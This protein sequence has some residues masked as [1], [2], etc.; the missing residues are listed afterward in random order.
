MTKYKRLNKI[1][2]LIKKDER[3]LDVG[4]DHCYIPI[5]L[6]NNKITNSITAS[7]INPKPLNIGEENLKNAGYSSKDVELIL[8]NGLNDIDVEYFD[9]IIIAGMGGQT[10]S[11]IIDK[12]KFNGR[13]IIHSTTSISLV[14]KTIQNIG[15][16]IIKEHLII[17]GKIYNILIEAIHGKMNLSEKE[18]FM[19]P[20]LMKQ[21]SDEV[22]EYYNFLLNTFEKNAI[23]SKINNLNLKERNWLKEKIWSEKN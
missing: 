10:I 9:T 15:M 5:F 6:L 17:E 18:L 4:T 16:N 8:T 3:V 20:S 13:Y 23:K 2:S 7:D 22:N 12:V 11:N 1:A 14:R 21:N 19:G